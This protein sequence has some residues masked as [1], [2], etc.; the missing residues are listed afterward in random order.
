MATR[1]SH[2]TDQIN[3]K[4]RLFVI[5]CYPIHTFQHPTATHRS[6]SVTNVTTNQIAEK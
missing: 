6:R 4:L 2:S 1:L 3:A 5:E